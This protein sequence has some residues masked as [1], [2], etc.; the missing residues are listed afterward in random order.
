MKLISS[1]LSIVFCS[2]STTWLANT[3]V[4]SDGTKVEIVQYYRNYRPNQTE[5][6][7]TFKDKKDNQISTVKIDR[8]RPFIDGFAEPIYINRKKSKF[9]LNSMH[10]IPSS[11]GRRT[12]SVKPETGEWSIEG[13]GTS[14]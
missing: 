6:V 14:G 3:H 13:G 2:C 12:L 9:L 4:G 7:L 10:P 5:L 1:F 8:I 11:G